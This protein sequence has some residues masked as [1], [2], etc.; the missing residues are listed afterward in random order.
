VTVGDL[1]RFAARSLWA[2]RVRSSLSLLAMSVGVAAVVV[3]TWLGES[4][5]A[6]IASQFESLGSNLIIVL[7]GRSETVGGMPPVL[8]AI[9][10]DLT[11][12]DAL[13]LRRSPHVYLVAPL[14]FGTAPIS[15]RGRERECPLLGSTEE[16]LEVRHLTVAQGRFLSGF[17]PHD[18]AGECVVGAKVKRELFGSATAIGEWVRVGD[19]RFRLVGVLQAMG[20]S[21][22]ADI[23][24]CLFVPVADA[25]ALFNRRSL[26]RILIRATRQDEIDACVRDVERILAARHGGEHDVTII[27][28][29]AVMGTLDSIMRALTLSVTGIAAISLIVA[30]ILIMNVMIVSVTQ[31]TAEIGLLKALGARRKT[32]SRAFVCEAAMLSL[33]GAVVG[34]VLGVAVTRIAAAIYPA[35]R[36]PVPTWALL[37]AV[38]VALGVGVLFGVWP[39]RRAARLDP[40]AA[41]ARR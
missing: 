33:A 26:F 25:L 19:R 3:L 29:D 17:D 18:G 11:I 24:E 22:G 14:A 41:L 15:Y 13:A 7:P 39:S 1:L 12:D 16:M 4:A 36:A 27:T 21:L 40:V 9:P 8:S 30:G 38:S 31:R 28:Q 37:A 20:T 35:L 34:L 5:R 6:Y 10:R 2:A 32:I 23:D